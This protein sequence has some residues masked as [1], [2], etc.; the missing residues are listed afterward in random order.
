MERKLYYNASY[1]RVWSAAIAA[2]QTGDLYILNADK[3]RGFILQ[4]AVGDQR[5]LVKMLE[6]GFAAFRR[7]KRR[8]KS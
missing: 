7:H 6:S 4:N 5:P 1:D 8:W 3:S 2:S